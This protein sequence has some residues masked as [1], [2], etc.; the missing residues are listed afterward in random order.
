MTNP[1][2]LRLFPHLLVTTS[3]FVFQWGS[4]MRL[5]PFFSCVI[6]KCLFVYLDDLIVVSKDLDR[7]LQQLSL[8]IQKLTQTGL[9]VK[10]TEYEFPK[11]RNKFLGHLV[12]GDGIHTL[13]SK[14]VA[15]QK[16]PTPKPVEN[17]RFFL[18]LAGYYRAFVK[19][20]AS[21][22]SPLRRLLKKDMP[23]LWGERWRGEGLG[24]G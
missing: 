24:N 15:V 9:K 4:G 23:F 6:G 10:L 21:I 8:V 12:D 13:D 19:N 2:K 16:F 3:G 18:G 14:I 20:F 1:G 22:A 7:H 5:L 11:S 17:V